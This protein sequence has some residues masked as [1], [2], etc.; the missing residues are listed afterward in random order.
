MPNQA[1]SAWT[2][3]AWRMRPTR[4]IPAYIDSDALGAVERR[5]AGSAPL[6][7]PAEIRCL[8]AHLA[9][10]ARGE[11]FVI[12]GGD[13]A[14]TFEATSFEALQGTVRTLQ[15]MAFLIGMATCQH[16]ITIGRI[17]GQFAKPRS[18][19]IETREGRSLPTYQGDI[20]N[21]REFTEQDR[22]AD[23][24][25]MTHAYEHAAATLGLTRVIARDWSGGMDVLF[26]QTM[27]A[28]AHLLTLPH[29]QQALQRIRATITL[30]ERAGPPVRPADSSPWP[31]FYTSHEALLLPYEQQL[32]RRDP[33]DGRW[34]NC[35]AHTVWVGDRTRQID[36]GH[37]EYVRGIENHIGV[38]C[39]PTL[40][41]EELCR[42]LDVINPGNATG[43]VSLIVRLGADRVGEVLYD[44]VRSVARRGHRVIWM[45]DPMHGN[46][47]Q[48]GGVKTREFGN[49][50]QEASTFVKILRS[51]G[52][53]PGGLHLELTGDDVTECV[54]GTQGVSAEALCD[55]YTSACDPR[56]NARQTLELA[57]GIVRELVC[58]AWP[59]RQLNG[60]A[61]ALVPGE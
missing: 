52:L 43:K 21:G 34:Y 51:E 7:A 28:S 54:G 11:A 2:P 25:R 10:V 19:S 23:P 33:E 15:Q 30:Q 59:D 27:S 26:Q 37:V 20:I 8:R 56:L 18:V 4:Q 36:G 57:F 42:L 40:S 1:G 5:L 41:S 38:K 35:S 53:H 13:C 12:Q 44:L 22:E 60:N 50:D 24:D 14:E 47:R 46:T 61:P 49:I 16:V 6:V 29:V 58:H 32:T 3:S 55:R 9:G 17:A 31:D 48:V 45:T 39:G